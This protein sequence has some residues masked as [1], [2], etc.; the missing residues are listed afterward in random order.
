MNHMKTF[1]LIVT[2][3]DD[4]VSGVTADDLYWKVH[5]MRGVHSVS[6]TPT[7][8]RT[9]MCDMCGKVTPFNSDV[10]PDGWVLDRGHEHGVCAHC[11]DTWQSET[12]SQCCRHSSCTNYTTDPSGLCAGHQ[13]AQS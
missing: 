13:G 2:V 10:P 5:A 11:Q 9:V 3:N 4:V 6:V 7:R 1:T 12:Q 8:G